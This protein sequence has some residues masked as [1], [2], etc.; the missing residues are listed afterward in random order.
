[1][2]IKRMRKDLELMLGGA[3]GMVRDDPQYLTQIYGRVT[4]Y[5]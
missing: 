3:Y 5:F 1:M 2:L 4:L